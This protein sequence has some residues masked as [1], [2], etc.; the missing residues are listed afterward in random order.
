MGVPGHLFAASFGR[1]RLG[2]SLAFLLGLMVYLGSLAMAAQSVL[3]GTAWRWE[4]DLQ[5]KVTIELAP[6]APGQGAALVQ[7]R[8]DKTLAALGAVPGLSDLAPVSGEQARA[9]IAPWLSDDKLVAQLPLPQLIDARLEDGA[10]P[11]ALTQ[12]VASLAPGARVHARTQGLGPLIG[13]LRGLS[14]LAFVLVGLTGGAVVAVVSI[15]CRAAMA[16]ER[17][18]IEL[19]HFMGAADPSIARAFRRHVARLAGRAAL[20]GFVAA[21]LTALGLVGLLGYFGGL[22]LVSSASFVIMGGAMGA[23]PLACFGLA[24]LGAHLSV[25]RLLRAWL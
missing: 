2:A 11:A 24:F 16:A 22:S 14:A 6:P 25:S 23:V 19:L 4:A 13:F 17:E 18:T 7:D 9:L 15:V 8:L 10:D 20:A 3:L 5:N 21:G 12:L 1:Q